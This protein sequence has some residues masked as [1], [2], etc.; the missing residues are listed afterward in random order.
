MREIDGEQGFACDFLTIIWRRQ[1]ATALLFVMPYI[2]PASLRTSPHSYGGWWGLSNG[3]PRVSR[4][5]MIVTPN[6][7]TSC[8]G[9][10]SQQR[11]QCHGGWC[12]FLSLVHKSSV[13]SSADCI[14]IS[15]VSPPWLCSVRRLTQRRNKRTHCFAFH[16]DVTHPWR[17][18]LM[19]SRQV[20][21]FGPPPSSRI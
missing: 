19:H 11:L 10:S 5:Q 4:L 13:T 20:L 14:D 21:R 16:K 15:T 2:L 9:V 1:A 12:L 17:T 18:I 7:P 8:S 6:P 3:I